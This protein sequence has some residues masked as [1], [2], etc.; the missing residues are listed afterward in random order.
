[1]HHRK[2]KPNRRAALSLGLGALGGLLLPRRVFGGEKVTRAWGDTTKVQA[3]R[4]DD[5]L[6]LL[7]L[8]GGNDGLSTII[9]YADDAYHAARRQTRWTKKTALPLDD[10]RAW[11]PHLA[12]LR[13]HYDQGH[14]A[15]VEG[16][17]YP[18]PN[19]SH[20]TS[21]DIWHTADLRGRA[22]GQG[23]L[24][25]LLDNVYGEDTDPRR[26]VHV[27]K[28]LPHMLQ[29][30][31]HPVLCVEPVSA[32]RWTGNPDQ[33]QVPAPN[34]KGSE[35]SARL[36]ST[37]SHARVAL[38]EVHQ[39]AGSYRPQVEY[40]D[41]PFA[42]KLQTIAGLI[43]SDLGC[44][45]LSVEQNGFDTHA[46]QRAAHDELM[47]VIGDATTAFLNDLK[48]TAAFNRTTVLIYSE[49]GR[50]VE[51]NGSLGTAHGAAN[52][53]FAAGG[54]V[55]GGNYGAPPSLTELDSE[56]DMIFNTDF[57]SVYANLIRD[58]FGADADVVLGAQYPKL[59]LLKA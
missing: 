48:G 47:R 4:G 10:Q 3:G 37:L 28:E 40:P 5:V 31:T 52:V 45:I 56:G 6:V 23:W 1:M 41:H 33:V 29:T 26:A 27:G 13:D 44:R 15:I 11:H 12:G 34:S 32:H 2:P 42:K 19:R 21:M 24:G 46:R 35:V 7:Q 8:R 43:Q 17:G 38:G 22:A 18:S 30:D 49:F 20:F 51:E 54:R 39:A 58:G 53:L 25:H 57:R 16:V 9:P 50:R 59:Q 36:H 55:R 14:V